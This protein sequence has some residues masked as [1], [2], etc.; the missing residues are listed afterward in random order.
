MEPD[1]WKLAKEY[2]EEFR[3]R[4]DEDN[5]K[6]SEKQ[7]EFSIDQ[8]PKVKFAFSY[9][10]LKPNENSELEFQFEEIRARKY[11]AIYEA[12][13]KNEE[14]FQKEIEELKKKYIKIT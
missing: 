8:C 1:Q 12:T 9:L 3:S 2:L 13:K 4:V 6:N 5:T 7:D 14:K 10:M 11:M